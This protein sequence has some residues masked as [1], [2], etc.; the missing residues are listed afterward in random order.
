[1]FLDT[2]T[3]IL[4]VPLDKYHKVK[5]VSLFCC[6]N[7]DIYSV[8]EHICNNFINLEELIIT[9]NDL[10]TIPVSIGNLTQLKR[11]WLNCSKIKKIPDEIG[12][13]TKLEE[14]ELGTT[15]V[16]TLPNSIAN[17]QNLSLIVFDKLA[18]MNKNVFI[19]S[20][21]MLVLRWGI[22]IK[23]PENITSLNILN[24][25][26]LFLNDLPVHIEHLKMSNVNKPLLN[27][28]P[29]LKTLELDYTDDI[30]MD[31]IRLPFG[32]E[33]IGITI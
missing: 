21:N 10:L 2:P 12:N 17:L 29:C 16:Y 8:F 15:Q 9:N 4:N 6:R 30:T 27:L 14:F 22:N 18:L 19:S 23:V 26:D 32:C 33:Y 28:P 11:L 5:E 13:L 31:D 25:H 20:V 1:M 24:A 3:Q 7:Y